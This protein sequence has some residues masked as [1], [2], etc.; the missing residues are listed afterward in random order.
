MHVRTL[1]ALLPLA[2]AVMTGCSATPDMGSVSA[3]SVSWGDMAPPPPPLPGPPPP[4]HTIPCTGENG[5]APV[6]QLWDHPDAVGTTLC[7]LGFGTIDLRQTSRWVQTCSFGI[8]TRKQ[9]KWGAAIRSWE[10]NQ[11]NL[12]VTFNSDIGGQ[13]YPPSFTYE[14]PAAP[15]PA[16]ALLIQV[17]GDSRYDPAR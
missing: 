16:A 6:V 5:V 3:S 17:L 13:A 7:L 11:Q 1:A 15:V 10:A 4:L 8:C 12:G 9:E 14:S 2:V